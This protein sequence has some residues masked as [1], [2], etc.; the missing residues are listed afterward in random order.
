MIIFRNIL[1]IVAAI[2]GVGWMF[3]KIYEMCR[4][5]YLEMKARLLKRRK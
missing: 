3:A 5:S 1:G 4:E 2:L